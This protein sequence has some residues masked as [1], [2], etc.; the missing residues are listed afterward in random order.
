MKLELMVSVLKS[1]VGN[2]FS[3]FKH[4]LV[5]FK[6]QIQGERLDGLP[7]RSTAWLTK[8]GR[9]MTDAFVNRFAHLFSTKLQAPAG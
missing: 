9:T 2:R 5:K 7:P 1:Q 8:G 6:G 3:V 4:G